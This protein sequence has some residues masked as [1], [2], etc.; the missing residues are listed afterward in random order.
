MNTSLFKFSLEHLAPSDWEH[1]ERLCSHFLASEF[2]S[3][4]TMAHPSGDGGRDSELFSPEGNSFVV[5]QYSVSTDWKA[6]IRK[7]KTRL[8]DVCPEAKYLIYL[9]NKQIGGQADNLKAEFLKDNYLLDVRDVAWFL[10]RASSCGANEDAAEELIDR[11]GRPYLEG[12]QIIES[13]TSP[14]STKE[15]HAALLYLGL[16][17]QDDITD[18]GLTKLSFDALVRAA[19][20]RSH[21]DKRVT[22]NA[23]YEDIFRAIPSAD[24][25]TVKN[26]VDSALKRLEKKI[27]RHW[28]KEDEFCLTYEEHQKIISKVA[29]QKS[30]ELIFFNE[31]SVKCA[32][33]F[34]DE[35]DLDSPNIEDLKIRIPRVIEKL[36]LKRGEDFVAAVQ[37]GNLVEIASEDLRNIIIED[38][39]MN[40]PGI[41]GIQHLPSNLFLIVQ[42]LL[43]QGNS[44]IQKYLRRLANSYTLLSFLNEV[45][46]VQ[47]ATKKLFSHGTI[48]LDTTIILPTIAEQLEEAPEK[49]KFSKIFHACKHA[50]VELRVTTGVI[51]EINAHMKKAYACSVKPSREWRGRVPFLYNCYLETGQ[52]REGFRNWIELFRG[53]ERPE[54]DLAQYLQEVFAIERVDLDGQVAVVEDDLRWSVERLWGEAHRN[55]RQVEYKGDEEIT[56]Q[57]I[58][59]DVENYLGV[60]SLRQAEQVTEFGYKHWLLTLDRLAWDI[61]DIIREEFHGQN[62]PSPIMSLSFLMNNLTFGPDRG[63]TGTEEQLGFPLLMDIDMADSPSVEILNIA[64]DVREDNVDL[65]EYVIRRKVRDAI[66]RAKR[67]RGWAS[68]NGSS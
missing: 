58:K 68:S 34:S 50:G 37:S 67:S 66:D 20:R 3:L 41:C 36:L 23:I 17:W 42:S 13:S 60:V 48:W 64:E 15:A 52:N 28:G 1:F 33:R 18:K 2:S 31:I 24:K 10:E 54:D 5:T 43:N 46:D 29:E 30:E 26:Q 16:Q 61:R 62:I 21:S 14:L 56:N 27:I 25:V 40:S 11:I 9:S 44:S 51:R 4:R 39:S 45:P 59:H 7:T 38:I 55:R 47:S 65:P 35:E 22:R 8:K 49:R 6:K 57:L 63:L 32:E 12:E 53:T 19:L